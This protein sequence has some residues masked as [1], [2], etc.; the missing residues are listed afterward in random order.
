MH[1]LFFLL[2]Y[3][4]ASYICKKV[5]VTKHYGRDIR[6]LHWCI[7]QMMT[8]ALSRI[9]LTASQGQVMGFLLMAPTPPCPRD[10]EEVMQ[11]SHPTVSGL[12][13]RLEKKGFLELRPDPADRR[14]KRIY[15][16]E[17]GREVASL[18]RQ[19]TQDIESRTL[20]GFTPEEQRQFSQF[21]SRATANLGGAAGSQTHKEGS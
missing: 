2:E 10:V 14:V 8:D 19:T 12:L 3:Y 4:V 1:F 9:G 21:L 15:V 6:V 16:L 11:L 7:D 18:M 5:I 17:Q 13:S 20:Q